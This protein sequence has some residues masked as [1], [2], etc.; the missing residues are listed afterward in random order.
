VSDIRAA[1][2]EFEGL[3]FD[4]LP[5]RPGSK[6]AFSRRWQS[7]DTS[8]LW[9]RAPQDA[10]IGLRAG[11]DASI[12][13]LDCDEDKRPGTFNTAVSWLAGLGYLPGDY[14]VVQTASLI[15]RQVYVA[16]LGGLPGNY[17]NLAN[18]FGAGEFRYGAGAYVAAP[19]S[20]VGD[21][22]YTLLSGDY[23]QLP[24]VALADVLT[25]LG[26][27][28]LTP[29]PGDK[30]P[31]IPRRAMALLNGK[32]VENFK[33]RSEAEQSLITSLIN[34]GHDFASVLALFMRYPCAG[35]FSELR[36]ESEKKAESW[37]RHS[38]DEAVRWTS[39]HESIARQTAAAMLE[40]AES[41]SW[42]GRTGAVDQAIFIA[43]CHIAYRAG[44]SVW[45]AA[46]RDLG[47]LAGVTHS[48][49][50]AAT[51]RLIDTN[52]LALN[53]PFIADSA[54]LYQFGGQS[55][56][57][58]N[59]FYVRKCQG[60]SNHDAFRKGKGKAGLGK[61]A[62]LVW[63]ALQGGPATEKEL[64]Q[65]TGR[66]PKTVKRAL[67]KMANLV[68]TV[69]GELIPMVE[70]NGGQWHALADVNL[71]HVA[72]VVGTAG[73]GER[74]RKRHRQ[75]RR[76]HRRALDFGKKANTEQSEETFIQTVAQANGLRKI[77]PS[78][79]SGKV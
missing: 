55:L 57:L 59:Y 78:G 62:A 54:A 49:A 21:S 41:I 58:P 12:A 11:G 76:A 73:A 68:D 16:F 66:S 28:D 1:R 10:N 46:C 42:P 43:H 51:R 74:Q 19:P 67:L 44:R 50:A 20:Q 18:D 79:D 5:L 61:S 30:S 25:I 17:R 75:E 13:F 63:Q 35:K 47:E 8:R 27:K 3:G 53:T 22:I 36:V 31:S 24:K 70:K 6:D 2:D 71:D 65:M 9:R 60:L 15:G 4:T 38:Y 39:T 29:V 52:L 45:A 64:A 14:P 37:L 7:S 23:R 48:T 72:Q 40:Q 56:T 26:N 33:S 77:R 34:A 32:H 69:T